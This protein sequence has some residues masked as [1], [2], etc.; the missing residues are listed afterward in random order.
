LTEEGYCMPNTPVFYGKRSEWDF[1]DS[2][3]NE[4]A[5]ITTALCTNLDSGLSAKQANPWGQEKR[6]V[7]TANS[8]SSS[9]TG[10]GSCLEVCTDTMGPPKKWECYVN[11]DASTGKCPTTGYFTQRQEDWEMDL[12]WEVSRPAFCV[13]NIWCVL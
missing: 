10:S 9:K 6:C 3:L 5:N 13:S 12:P 2:W 11:P 4:A 1:E 8:M 7:W